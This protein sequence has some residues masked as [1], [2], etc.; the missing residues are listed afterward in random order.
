M[1]HR[2]LMKPLLK[3]LRL[4][5]LQRVLVARKPRCE[6]REVFVAKCIIFKKMNA[7]VCHF[8]TTPLLL[9]LKD[10][11]KQWEN[12]HNF[13]LGIFVKIKSCKNS[14]LSIAERMDNLVSF[15]LDRQ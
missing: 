8:H 12:I 14:T 3:E 10:A 9:A 11:C 13:N 1:K 6:S 7:I 2:L 15:F 4:I 5:F